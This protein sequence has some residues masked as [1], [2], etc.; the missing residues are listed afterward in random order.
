MPKRYW[1]RRA[2]RRKRGPWP[3]S[4]S[5]RPRLTRARRAGRAAADTL[6]T[7]SAGCVPGSPRRT[8]TPGCARTRRRAAAGPASSATT[9]FPRRCAPAATRSC[10]TASRARD[11]RLADGRH[12]QRRRHH[13]ARRLPRRHLGHVLHRRRR[14]PRRG[15]WSRWRAAAATPASPWCATARASATSARRSRSSPRREGCAWCATR[16]PRH[17]PQHAH[18]RRTSSHVGRR[19]H[20]PAP[21]RR[22]G[23]HHRADDQPRAA[24]AC[25]CS[26]TAGRW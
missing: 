22:H 11:E 13:R 8:S 20:G 1:S 5:G 24:R 3:S 26:T 4:S 17:R 16:R 25:A 10:A 21:A 9:A 15:T 23:L 12:R 14:A 6:A 2:A 18:G 7:S 19:G